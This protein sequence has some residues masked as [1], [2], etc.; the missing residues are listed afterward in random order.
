MTEIK[1]NRKSVRRRV[2]KKGH[3]AYNDGHI[4]VECQVKNLSDQGARLCPHPGLPVPDHFELIIELD[5]KSAPSE[6]VWRNKTDIGIRFT[7]PLTETKLTRAQVISANTAG[8]KFR[9]KKE[10]AN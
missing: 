9:L 8:R 10:T 5:G 6:V 4:T 2:L 7:S 1:D 3:I